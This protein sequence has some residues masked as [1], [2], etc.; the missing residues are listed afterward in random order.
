MTQPSEPWTVLPSPATVSLSQTFASLR[1]D[2]LVESTPP[3]GDMPARV[4]E[5]GSLMVGV[6]SESMGFVTRCERSSNDVSESDDY[7]DEFPP[8][9]GRLKV[10]VKHTF[11]DGFEDGER[12]QNLGIQ[13]CPVVRLQQVPQRVKAPKMVGGSSM[14]TTPASLG[15]SS[16]PARAAMHGT[17]PSSP[18]ASASSISMGFGGGWPAQLSEQPAR[19]PVQG[20]EPPSSSAT[21][22][23]TISALF[24]D[25][26]AKVH[27]AVSPS[28]PTSPQSPSTDAE[29][30]DAS[31]V[32]D[33]QPTPSVGSSV[34]GTGQCKPCAWYWKP[35]GCVNAEKCCHCHLC[36]EGELKAR[37]KERVA[38]M[39]VG[40][41]EPMVP[42]ATNGGA[43]T[44]RITP[45]LQAPT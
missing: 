22:S 26:P 24:P 30:R 34:H 8:D 45:L 29:V 27:R 33:R 5:A 23:M 9:L 21:S 15:P 4:G 17:C 12:S 39:R 6:D 25:Q 14:M 2:D 10:K 43:R 3:F 37:K 16:M 20:Q 44:L 11:I 7:D 13:S 31:G 35:Q 28:S 42:G 18:T 36:P 40:A 32:G 1:G 38:A 41:L 19:V